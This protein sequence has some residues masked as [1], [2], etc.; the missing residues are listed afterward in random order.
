MAVNSNVARVTRSLSRFVGYAFG[1]FLVIKY[2]P[3]L[4]S[5]FP[6]APFISNKHMQVEASIELR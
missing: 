6:A 2:F 3:E 5:I 1:K 4:L